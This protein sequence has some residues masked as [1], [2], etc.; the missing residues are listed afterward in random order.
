MFPRVFVGVSLSLY[1]INSS[2]G[3]ARLEPTT[4]LL[5]KF[6]LGVGGLILVGID[7]SETVVEVRSPV[8]RG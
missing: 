4:L 7:R 3:N 2:R 5:F 8:G 1:R 6:S